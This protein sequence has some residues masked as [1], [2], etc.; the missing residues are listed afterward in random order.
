MI[1]N[2]TFYIICACIGGALFITLVT[3]IILWILS[4]NKSSPELIDASVTCPTLLYTG[5]DI[6]NPL[7][8]ELTCSDLIEAF[9]PELA[10]F[11]NKDSDS[12]TCN[13][14]QSILEMDEV[15]AILHVDSIPKGYC[16]SSCCTIGKYTPTSLACITSENDDAT[17]C[18]DMCVNGIESDK[19]RCD[20]GRKFTYQKDG[21]LLDSWTNAT[22]NGTLFGDVSFE[23][24][25][26][27]CCTEQLKSGLE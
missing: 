12:L 17:L 5:T 8:T 9:G 20:L 4:N 15:K 1:S 24:A 6:E 11:A 10:S 18:N 19:W 3:F 16:A 26:S 13:D 27:I 22:Y 23:K 14:F 7:K 25:A 21:T 2:F